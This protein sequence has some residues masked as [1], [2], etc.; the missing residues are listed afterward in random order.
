MAKHK[1]V[2]CISCDGI[3]TQ[4]AGRFD[5]YENPAGVFLF[6]LF[7]TVGSQF[8]KENDYLKALSPLGNS[9]QTKV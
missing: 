9:F 5:A 3:A 1:N 6:I 8:W 4:V 7:S 2:E